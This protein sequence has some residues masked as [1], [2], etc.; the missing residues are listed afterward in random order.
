MAT[1]PK[2]INVYNIKLFF[3]F[4]AIG[5]NQIY[6]GMLIQFNYR[7]PEGIH[8]KG[9]LI[10]VLE[11]QS[12]R[13]YGLNIHYD[14]KLMQQVVTTKDIELLSYKPNPTQ[15]TSGE[16]K[17]TGD[18]PTVDEIK[19]TMKTIP[20]GLLEKYTL[21]NQPTFILRNYLFTRMSSIVKL[22]YK[23]NF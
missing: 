18:L 1:H 19:K 2:N 4:K 12:D 10:Y 16:T 9:P 7:S 20:P 13:V 21:I 15:P 6:P 8:D 17:G 22:I 11:V 23:P 14:F 5:V 3:D